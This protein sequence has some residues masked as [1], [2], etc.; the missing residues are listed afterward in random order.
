[1]RFH[2]EAP[3]AQ[4]PEGCKLALDPSDDFNHE[5]DAVSNYNESMYF[6]VFDLDQGMGGWYRIGNRVNEGYAEMTNCWYLPDGRVAFMAGR[7]HIE[8][9][10]VMNAGGMQFEIVEPFKR[11]CITYEGKM[12]V[13]ER[14]WEMLEPSK[15]FRSNPV[16]PCRMEMEHTTI[17]QCHGGEVVREDGRKLPTDSEKGFAKAHFEQFTQGQGTFTIG[18]ETFE[19]SG[20]GVRDKSWGPR[21]WQSIDWYRWLTIYVNPN[22]S[23]VATFMCTEGKMRVSGM[24]FTPEAVHDIEVGEL[25]S[26]WDER[27][28]QK[29]LRFSTTVAGVDYEVEGDVFSLIPLR[30]RRETPTGELLHTRI[31]EGMAHYTVNGE[32]ALGIAEYLDQIVD[33]RPSGRTDG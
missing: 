16:V 19:L 31:A 14:P 32:R 3:M 13:L 24:L 26:E 15:A 27:D 22:L 12:C 18:D 2:K 20:R 17:T 11:H 6:S 5:P 8:T 30:N 33:G 28:C 23:M 7:P 9:N 1:M 21:Y 29:S 10:E 4:L 25:H